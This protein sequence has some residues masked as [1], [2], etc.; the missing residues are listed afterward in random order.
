MDNR[1]EAEARAPRG[2]SPA[3]GPL[4]ESD[5][6][7][8]DRPSRSNARR[9]CAVLRRVA[10]RWWQLQLLTLVVSAPIAF[11]IYLYV[12]PT[13]VASSILRI[14]PAQQDVFG[15]LNRDD[16]ELKGEKFLKTQ[17]RMI[18]T[19]KVLNPAVADQSVIGLPTIRNSDDPKSDLR[20][21]LVV[22]ILEDTNLIRVGLE[23]TDAEEAVAIVQAVVQSYL[24][25]N[26]D[27]SRNANRDR[28]KC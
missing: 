24:A 16:D 12:R 23:L 4:P 11:L 3:S 22:E 15:P 14:E 19:D 1:D 26:K 5:P 6:L 21:K 13:Y 10:A 7:S 27:Y 2:H 8:S 9:F 20:K 18:T 25:Q 28:R 17:V